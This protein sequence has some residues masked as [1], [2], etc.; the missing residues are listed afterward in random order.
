MGEPV[1]DNSQVP[2]ELRP[3]DAITQE[4]IDSVPEE[5]KR[6]FVFDRRHGAW[7]INNETAELDFEHSVAQPEVNKPE[8]WKLVNKSGGWWHP[9]HIHLEFMRVLTRNGEIPPTDEQDG[10]S[11]TDTVLLGPNDEVDVYFNFRD[12]PGPW[13][14]HCHNIEHE[15]MRMMARFDVVDP[16][17]AAPTENTE[18]TP[19]SLRQG[20]SGKR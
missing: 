2:E 10:F 20:K 6:T 12:F 8:I 19:E 7:T 14:F 18:E 15:D 9:I 4:E 11:K 17:T 5:R 16:E 1:P 3:F 13:V